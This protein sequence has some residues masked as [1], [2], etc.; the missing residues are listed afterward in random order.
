MG[1]R[2][3]RAVVTDQATTHPVVDPPRRPPLLAVGVSVLNQSA[4][5]YSPPLGPTSSMRHYSSF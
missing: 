5:L 1:A 3:P 2:A 4:L